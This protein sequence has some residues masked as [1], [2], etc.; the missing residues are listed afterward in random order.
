MPRSSFWNSANTLC[1]QSAIN[2]VSSTIPI[3]LFSK[4]RN[5]S[6]VYRRNDSGPKT[7]PLAEPYGIPDTTLTSLYILRQPFTIT[8]CD[9]FA[10]NCANIDNTDLQHPQSRANGEFPDGWPY[11]MLRWNQS[12]QFISSTQVP[13]CPLSNKLCSKWGKHKRASQVPRPV[14]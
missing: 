8:C 13:S 11:Q 6:E 12:A 4:M 5:S 2:V 9:R 14:R 3:S 1:H 10:R 7:L